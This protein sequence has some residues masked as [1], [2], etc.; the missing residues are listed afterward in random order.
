MPFCENCGHQNSNAARFCEVC[1]TRLPV[2]EQKKPEQSGGL[3]G[4]RNVIAG[5]VSHTV[6]NTTT[7]INADDGKTTVVCHI[8]G[9]LLTKGSGQVYRCGSCGEFVCSDHIDHE[10]HKCHKCIEKDALAA[11]RNEFLPFEYEQL[12]TG[13]FVITKLRDRAAMEVKVPD[14]VE[15][16]GPKA[17]AGSN[18][19]RVT[20]PEG[21][22]AIG[23]EAFMDCKQLKQINLP[24]SLCLIADRAFYGCER[25][26]LTLR[27]GM[28]LGEDAIFGTVTYRKAEEAKRKAEEEAR[29]KAEEAA[30]RAE[31]DARRRAEE[32]KRRAEEAALRA[33]AEAKRKA[34]E[35]A[36][37]KAEEE[38]RRKAEEEAKRRAAEE[39]KIQAE[40]QARE[41][42]RKAK[43]EAK[44][45]AQEEIERN[46]RIENGILYE[47][48][49]KD[50][51]VVVPEGVR[52]IGYNAFG[53]YSSG[54]KTIRN[55]TLPSSVC[56]PGRWLFCVENVYI[57]DLRAWCSVDADGYLKRGTKLYVNRQLLTKLVIPG[58]CQFV[59]GLFAGYKEL[60][61]VTFADNMKSAKHTE[62]IP[63][64]A[65]EGCEN[66]E[67][68]IL[69]GY[70][71]KIGKKAFA[72]CTSLKKIHL[73]NLLK[74]IDKEA[75]AGCTALEEI[76]LPAGLQTIEEKAFENCTAL[77][78]VQIP[79]TV[80]G[81]KKYAFAGCS[82]LREVTVPKSLEKIVSGAFQNCPKVTIRYDGTKE[83]FQKMHSICSGASKAICSDGELELTV[84]SEKALLAKH[85]DAAEWSILASLFAVILL[86]V[87]V[88]FLPE[89]MGLLAGI[90]TA[91]VFGFW[92]L[93][94]KDV[95]GFVNR[96]SQKIGNSG[97]LDSYV[98]QMDQFQEGWSQGMDYL[99]LGYAV[100]TFVGA[101]ILPAR[102]TSTAILMGAFCIV[103]A[104][105]LGAGTERQN[106]CKVFADSYTDEWQIW[107]NVALFVGGAA[108]VL[109][110]WWGAVWYATLLLWIAILLVDLG[111]AKL[112]AN[113]ILDEVCFKEKTRA[114]LFIL[115]LLAVPALITFL[116][117]WFL[118]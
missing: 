39:A 100:A 104:L 1:G 9:K 72:G 17:F 81:M 5:D 6:T 12:G 23:Q 51:D 41:A 53:D 86:N 27:Q 2:L 114:A 58:D 24:A 31:E 95:L 101:L 44:R 7:Y 40:R 98:W 32:A 29:R 59:S 96:W 4:D 25:L 84:Y 82:E 105:A 37:R 45:K 13:K 22:L 91:L 75:F 74:E 26:E 83:Q 87:V 116:Y 64:G 55:L 42:E 34:E 93:W 103:N 57:S 19:F 89:S 70:V 48:R 56:E 111:I 117:V 20:L 66:L 16:I 108:T 76:N 102:F 107:H 69:P 110:L 112:M 97:G 113:N 3:L 71:Q 115:V 65:F 52:A 78:T 8:C 15:S 38:A 90:L 30:R 62:E 80:T 10:Q 85:K 35:E 11:R 106:I 18:V 67:E 109:A 79:N 54:R 36:R 92:I 33:A 43:E 68:V 21:L 49:G 47:Y 94:T 46:F 61:S 77:R 60:V 28:D 99:A 73:P 50:K 88:F 118:R 63:E 14:M